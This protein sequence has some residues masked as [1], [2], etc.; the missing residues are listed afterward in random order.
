MDLAPSEFL[1]LVSPSARARGAASFARALKQKLAE[2]HYAHN[3]PRRRRRKAAIDHQR[4]S[5]Y[6]NALSHR[7]APLIP[8]AQAVANIVQPPRG[9][10]QRDMLS[11]ALDL[12]ERDVEQASNYPYRDGKSYLARVGFRALF[13]IAD[14]LGA[15]DGPT[16]SRIAEWLTAAPGMTVPQ[17]TDVVA[18]LSRIADCHNA[19]LKLATHVEKLILLDTDIGSRVGSYGSLAQS[20][21]RVSID[22]ASVFFRRT[23]DLTDAIGSDDFERANHLLELTSHYVGPELSASAAHNLARILELES[24]RGFEISLDRICSDDGTCR[25]AINARDARPSRRSR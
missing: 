23:L 10:S 19:A 2:P 6:N 20:V 21:W 7:I 25:R 16:A 11:A 12:L 15:I 9:R 3:A 4:R 5:E 17:L 8:Y 24:V 14:A 22:E 18:R 1:T 13:L